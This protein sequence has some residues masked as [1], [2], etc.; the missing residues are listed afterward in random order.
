MGPGFELHN[1]PF[2]KKRA[3]MAR[4]KLAQ[5]SGAW[6]GGKLRNWRHAAAIG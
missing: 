1:S 4:F 6:R 5:P 3:R 2:I